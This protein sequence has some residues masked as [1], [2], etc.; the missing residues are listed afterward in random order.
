VKE[1]EALMRPDGMKST[2][3]ATMSRAIA[4]SVV[5]G[6]DQA[7]SEG[8]PLTQLQQI[9]LVTMAVMA[10]HDAVV[11]AEQQIDTEVSL[12]EM[13]AKRKAAS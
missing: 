5:D 1:K 8:R 2:F 11:D 3:R 13:V 10:Y 4:A 12:F 7:A 9:D 6:I